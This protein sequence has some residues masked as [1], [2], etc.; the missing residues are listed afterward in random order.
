MAIQSHLLVNLKAATWSAYQGTSAILREAGVRHEFADIPRSKLIPSEIPH[1][2]KQIHSDIILEADAKTA[3]DQEQRPEGDGIF[4]TTPGTRVAVKT[5]DC[6]PV[7]IAARNGTFACAIHAGW[8]GL[9]SGILPRAIELASGFDR[10][11]QLMVAIGP[12]I[13][14]EQFEV[15]DDVIEGIFSESASLSPESRMLCIAKGRG[16]RWHVDLPLA[17]ACQ[18]LGHGIDSRNLEIIQSCTRTAKSDGQWIHNSY[19]RD[20]K[21]CG[22][23][24]S[25]I[26]L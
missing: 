26:S 12:A 21:G 17:A 3:W 11:D 7:L 14:R 19:R 24:W 13:S 10:R 18:A 6:L 9:T 20:G 5:A 16:D 22:S 1:H 23:N 15:G 25:W 4:T 2:V 8:R